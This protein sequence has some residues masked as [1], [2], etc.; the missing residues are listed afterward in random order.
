MHVEVLS[1]IE[2]FESQ[3][4]ERP[5]PDAGEVL[6][7]MRNVGICGSDVHYWEHGRIGDFVVEGD[8][9]LGHESAG[10]VVEVGEDVTDLEAGMEVTVEPNIPC[11]R[12][13]ACK[14]G[15][16]HLCDDI[17]FMA[18]PPHD[19]AFTEYVAWPADFVYELPESV[20]TREG[21]LCEPISVCLNACRRGNVDVGDTVLVT[22]CGPIGQISMQVAYAFGADE[23]I[24]TDVVPAKLDRA[25]E[26]GAAHTVNVAETDLEAEI[27]EYTDGT[28]VDVVIEASGAE[29]A[30][31]STLDVVRRGGTVVLLG[32]PIEGEMP[33]DTLDI[34]SNEIDVHGS[35]RF[36]NTYPDAISLLESGRVDVDGLIDFTQPLGEV[37]DAFERVRDDDSVVKGM[38]EI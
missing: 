26:H 35:F 9:V 32:M 29:P 5:E 13:E 1:D 20:S 24:T 38:I 25:E 17:E 27:E 37:S 2:E 7:R 8:L 12:C 31:R 16:Y 4:R 34:I 6:V 19:G 22:G 18:T 23:V 14:R 30:M 21:A 15:N 11:R 10:E 33:L 3:E 36:R 28:G